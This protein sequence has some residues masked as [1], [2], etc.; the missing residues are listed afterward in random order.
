V[1]GAEGFTLVRSAHSGGIA[2]RLSR[3]PSHIRQDGH[4]RFHLIM[5]SSGEMTLSQLGRSQCVAGG[6]FA[7]VCESN[8]CVIETANPTEGSAMTRLIMPRQLVDQR[9]SAGE[10]F[11]LRPFAGSDGLRNLIA[12]MLDSL[13]QNAWILT[14]AEF[15]ASA[16]ALADLLLLALSQSPDV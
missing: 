6:S 2:M 14:S 11:C 1:R 3:R 15:A 4:H 10:R 7:F 13:G 12:G 8:P 9:L 5:T 16:R